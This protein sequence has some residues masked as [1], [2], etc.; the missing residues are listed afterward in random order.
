[1]SKASK[2]RKA[3]REAREERRRERYAGPKP[4]LIDQYVEKWFGGD[5]PIDR[6]TYSDG[7]AW[8]SID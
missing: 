5:G 7:S 2:R 4:V 3:K 1:M 6:G 8:A